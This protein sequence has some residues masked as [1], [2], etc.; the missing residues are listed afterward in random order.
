[1]KD[2]VDAMQEKDMHH[3]IT[4]M[5]TPLLD[6]VLKTMNAKDGNAQRVKKCY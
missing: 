3:L 6:A 4:Q 2:T 1:M 5:I